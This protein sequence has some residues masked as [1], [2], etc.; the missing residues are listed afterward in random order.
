MKELRPAADGVYR[1]CLLSVHFPGRKFNDNENVSVFAR[2]KEKKQIGKWRPIVSLK[3]LNR[4]LRYT[5]F[6][7]TTVGD[8]KSWIIKGNNFTSFNRFN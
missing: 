2:P 7:M 6:R 3:Y 1:H 8:V 4:Y 5:K